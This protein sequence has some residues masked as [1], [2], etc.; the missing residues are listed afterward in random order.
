MVNTGSTSVPQVTFK[1]NRVWRNGGDQVGLW[2]P[3]DTTTVVDLSGGDPAISC[4]ATSN[5]QSANVIGRCHDAEDVFSTTATAAAWAVRNY[6]QGDSP[7]V[8]NANVL[9]ACSWVSPTCPAP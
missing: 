8:T 5:R 2:L 4:D 6:W 3:P 7:V 9:H 1:G